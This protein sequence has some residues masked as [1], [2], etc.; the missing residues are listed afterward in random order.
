MFECGLSGDLHSLD[1]SDKIGIEIIDNGKRSIIWQR[2]YWGDIVVNP[3][4]KL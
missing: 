2:Q 3:I 1:Q 4:I